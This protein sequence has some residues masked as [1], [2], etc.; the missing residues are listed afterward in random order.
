MAN[1]ILYYSRRGENYAGGAVVRLEK[2]NTEIV[3][4]YIQ[5]A[6]G[7]ELFELETE[8]PLCRRLRHVHLAGEGRAGAGGPPGTE[9]QPAQHSRRQYFHLRPVLVGDVSLRGI[10]SDRAAGFRGKAR[11]SR[12]D[13]HEGSGLGRGVRDLQR[14]CNGASFGEA[15]RRG[16]PCRAV[17]AGDCGLGALVR[18]KPE[19]TGRSRVAYGSCDETCNRMNKD[20]AG[21]NIMEKLFGSKNSGSDACACRFW[22]TARSIR[23][24]SQKWWIGLWNAALRISTRRTATSPAN[25]SRR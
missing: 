14:L 22:K 7:G 2:G 17:G 16:K 3:A 24:C 25:R 4:E 10:Q 11:L 12:H 15:G 23:R 9:K 20:T 6:V 18:M 19:N 13:A 1:L 8:K 21:G 5:R